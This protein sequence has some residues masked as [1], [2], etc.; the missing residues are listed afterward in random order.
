MVVQP[1][2]FPWLPCTLPRCRT[3]HAACR[4]YY[5]IPSL[6]CVVP[7]IS[8]FPVG[9]RPKRTI[10]NTEKPASALIVVPV[11]MAVWINPRTLPG[12]QE[13]QISMLRRQ[14]YGLLDYHTQDQSP[15]S[16]QTITAV[17]Y[18]ATNQVTHMPC[19]TAVNFIRIARPR[20]RLYSR[21]Q[22]AM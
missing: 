14:S 1:Q 20:H 9:S 15:I 13:K 19:A 17:V 2:C 8:R 11:F 21:R 22:C 16:G 6:K 10:R 3:T 5:H 12:C 4:T 7:I 18:A